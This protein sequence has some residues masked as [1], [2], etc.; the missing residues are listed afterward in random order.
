MDLPTFL[1]STVTLGK[2]GNIKNI[3][4]ISSLINNN[5][6]PL[7]KVIFLLLSYMKNRIMTLVFWDRSLGIMDWY[8]QHQR[9]GL[10]IIKWERSLNGQWCVSPWDSSVPVWYWLEG[11]CPWPQNIKTKPS[12]RC[13]ISLSRNFGE[14]LENKI[15][16]IFYQ[17]F[18]MW[19][20]WIFCW[21]F[22]ASKRSAQ[23]I[24]VCSITKHKTL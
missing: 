6:H 12:P 8:I 7:N 24:L 1:P 20:E 13:S 23:E 9:L 16:E 2:L 14:T 21:I 22:I 5:I 18:A 3:S 10:T 15:N 19:D 4:N 11:C 17:S